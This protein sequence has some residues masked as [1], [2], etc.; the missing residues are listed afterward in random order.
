M[1]YI[2][3]VSHGHALY[4]LES[5]PKIANHQNL[6]TIVI[7]DNLNDKNIEA[8][9]KTCGVIYLNNMEGV[10]NGFGKNN[11]IAVKYIMEN[12]KITD[13]DYVIIFNPDVYM[14]PEELN[15]LCRDIREKKINYDFFTI[16][17]FTDIDS[18][19]RDKSVR[20]F[21]RL[22]DFISSYIFHN[23]KTVVTRNDILSPKSVDWFSG[24]FMAIRLN[25]FIRLGGFDERYF[26]YCEDLDLC[27]R[28]SE[29]NIQRFYLPDYHAEHKAQHSNR[30]IF[31]RA[32]L[33]HLI[34]ILRYLID[35][36][37][38]DFKLPM[39]IKTSIRNEK[40]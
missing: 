1:V 24:A 25:T 27:R 39:K 28:A 19:K 38:I 13:D 22:S 6:Y 5:I 18:H 30:R 17:L 16:D 20:T 12:K 14:D 10:P 37:L 3:I 26:M 35:T 21:P 2:I 36:V 4:L 31:S 15:L 7:R 34:S 8:M 23:D 33:Y 32:F 40:K 11:N 29:N 9:C